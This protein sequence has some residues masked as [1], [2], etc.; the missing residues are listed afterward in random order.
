MSTHAVTLFDDLVEALAGLGAQ[1]AARPMAA[2]VG[3]VAI[4]DATDPPPLGPGDVVL[5]VGVPSPSLP[6]LIES[7]AAAHAMAVVAKGAGL[8]EASVTAQARGV[9]L[10]V[11]P[12]GAPWGEILLLARS[13][14]AQSPSEIARGRSS[15]SDAGELSELADAIASRLNAPVTIE[16][17]SGR[18]LGYSG[19]QRRADPGRVQ[20]ILERR[21]PPEALQ[22]LR[23]NGVFRELAASDGPVL[24][25]PDGNGSV[26]RV[27]M[28]IRIGN[29]LFGTLWAIADEEPDHDMRDA[30]S[31]AAQ[32]AASQLLHDRIVR[33]AERDTPR[34]ILR[35]L[36]FG[37][38]AP[39]ETA[40]RLG[41]SKNGF[42]VL[43][44]R[45]TG[46]EPHQYRAQYAL[47]LGSNYLRLHLRSSPL[48]AASGELDCVLYA[49]LGGDPDSKH[50][51]EQAARFVDR[52]LSRAGHELPET[53][54]VGIGGHVGS[55]EELARSR[56]QADS[57]LRV[58]E[59]YRTRYAAVD[60]V[61]AQVRLLEYSERAACHALDR[62]GPVGRLL[63]HDSQHGTA[64]VQTL[65]AYFD[66]FGDARRAGSALHVHPA[67]VRYRIRRIGEITGVDLR[68]PPQRLALMLDTHAVLDAQAAL[69]TAG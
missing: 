6:A 57:V 18:V 20:S 1:V 62:S 39:A 19:D 43:A 12:A 22:L 4:Y 54:I 53:T 69:T 9:G 55:I 64:Y 58:L 56:D 45:V 60:D 52:L 65:G 48:I 31:E 8:E 16:D 49:V 10:V 34:H 26:A 11:V 44:M 51:Y 42:R 15:V 29:E 38:E 28:S 41:V 50:S 5:A 68:D 40:W 46:G 32:L 3:D 37:G 24:V 27:G 23:R 21:T 66:A 36:L 47:L 7:S 35:P 2:S 25:S 63:E 33:H 67:T 13:V 59:K 14:T 30:L 61:A 17:V